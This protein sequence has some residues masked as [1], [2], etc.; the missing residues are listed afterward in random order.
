MFWFA[1]INIIVSAAA[2]MWLALYIHNFVD[3]VQKWHD[4]IGRELFALSI[5]PVVNIFVLIMVIIRCW[6]ALRGQINPR[7]N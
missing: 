7:Y 4:E 1:V 2:I 3:N 5:V 6:Y